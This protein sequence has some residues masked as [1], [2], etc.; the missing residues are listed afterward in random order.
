MTPGAI[1]TIMADLTERRPVF[2]SEADFQHAIAMA[3]TRRFPAV[4]VRLEYRASRLDGKAY[5]DIWLRNADRVMAIELKYKTAPLS[6]D[7]DGELFDLVNQGACDHGRSMFL[8]DVA[9]V[10]AI[11]DRYP[12]STGAAIMLT[13]DPKYWRPSS[14]ADT[15]DAAFHINE[16][17]T[18]CK[19]LQW[20]PEASEKTRKPAPNGI[21]L[22][23]TYTARWHDYS[24]VA[25]SAFRWLAFVARLPRG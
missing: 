7:I 15:Y 4:D 11:A 23:G 12:N 14:R 25:G 17:R 18:I 13:N 10:E 3:I 16:G 9:R 5:I 8:A 24:T 20:H 22:D 1:P 2:Q 21:T 19:H 6:H